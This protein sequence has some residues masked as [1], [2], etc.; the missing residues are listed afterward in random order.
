MGLESI[1]CVGK[2]THWHAFNDVTFCN[3]VDQCQP[4]GNNL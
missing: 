3:N 1:K 2:D 4:L